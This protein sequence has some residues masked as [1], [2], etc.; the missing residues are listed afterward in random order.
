[1]QNYQMRSLFPLKDKDDYKFAL[2]IEEIV[3]VVHCTLV[4]SRVM[5]KLDETNIRSN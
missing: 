5:Q 1:M 2:S 3:L 4:K